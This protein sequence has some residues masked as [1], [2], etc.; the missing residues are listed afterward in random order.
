MPIGYLETVGP[1]ALFT[2]AVLWPPRRPAALA[3]VVFVLTHLLNEAPAIGWIWLLTS[4]ALAVAGG[5]LASAGGAAVAALAV[6]TAAGLVEVT[7]RGL[8]TS[9]AVNHALNHGLG[10]RHPPRSIDRHSGSSCCASR[11]RWC[12]RY[13]GDLGR[14]GASATSAT[15]RT[16]VTTCSICI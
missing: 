3:R 7:R 1:V 10:P 4:T 6:F 8:R 11:A 9:R 14:S 12:C 5:Q 16:A 13:R 2:L 15:A